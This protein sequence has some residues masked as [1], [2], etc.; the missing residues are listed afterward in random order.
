[1]KKQ[2]RYKLLN[3]AKN[4]YSKIFK[5][6]YEFKKLSKKDLHKL[7]ADNKHSALCELSYCC[8]GLY[9][10]CWQD[11]FEEGIW[12]LSQKEVDNIIGGIIDRTAKICRKDSRIL[13]YEDG[14]RVHVII[15]A[16]DVE[17]MDYL[18]TF[19]NIV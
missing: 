17:S 15:I 2:E 19:T 7:L 5:Q 11:P 14:V 18:I 12:D 16:R 6:N 13:Y 1:M 10:N 9:T 4:D 3:Y 8:Y